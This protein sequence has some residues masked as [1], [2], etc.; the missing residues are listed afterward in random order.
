MLRGVPVGRNIV[1]NFRGLPAVSPA[2]MYDLDLQQEVCARAG[3]TGR[4]ISI[5]FTVEMITAV[6]R[7]RRSTW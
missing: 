2:D 6:S 4:L 5:P 1:T 3:V 7:R